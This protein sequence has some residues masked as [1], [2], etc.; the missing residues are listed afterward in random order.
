[1]HL[2]TTR[3]AYELVTIFDCIVPPPEY[4]S[5]ERVL[6]NLDSVSLNCNQAFVR[7]QVLFYL[8]ALIVLKACYNIY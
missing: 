4:S 8:E 7:S 3:S 6:I 1:M 2:F 5:L